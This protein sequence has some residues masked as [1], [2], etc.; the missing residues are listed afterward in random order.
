[1]GLRGPWETADSYPP[2]QKEIH[3]FRWQYPHFQSLHFTPSLRCQ[4]CAWRNQFQTAPWSRLL[5]WLSRCVKSQKVSQNR[6]KWLISPFSYHRPDTA[7]IDSLNPVSFLAL[8]SVSFW[9]TRPKTR[10]IGQSLSELLEMAYFATLM[11]WFNPQFHK[12]AKN[13]YNQKL[14]RVKVPKGTPMPY[15]DRCRAT[16][17]VRSMGPQIEKKEF[18]DSE[19]PHAPFCH[20]PS[21]KCRAWLQ[22]ANGASHPFQAN[23]VRQLIYGSSD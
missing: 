11:C 5:S 21:R 4:S 18:Y 6:W 14:K 19:Y 23:E 2:R 10:K 16:R 13:H 3:L 20:L 8:L 17:I 7:A 9:W 22:R 15:P 12:T 1:M